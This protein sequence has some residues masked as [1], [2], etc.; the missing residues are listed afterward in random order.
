VADRVTAL[1]PPPSSTGYVVPPRYWAWLGTARA[2]AALVW[3]VVVISGAAL[4][5]R[6]FHWGDDASDLPPERMRADGNGAH[7]QIDFGG[8]W[9]M[10]RMMATGHGREL[11]HRQRQ[12]QILNEAYPVAN[13]SVIQREEGAL[14][15]SFQTRARPGEEWQHDSS[16]LMNWFMGTDPDEWKKVGGASV[17]PLA[18]PPT[19]N[20]LVA[21]ALE[22]AADDAVTPEIVAKVNEPAVGGPLYPP[23]HAL[24]YAPLGAI[25]HPQQA[26]HLFQVICALLIPVAGLGVKVLTRG[27][28][29]WSVATLCLFFYPGTRGG[30]DLGQNPSISLCI[31]IWGW[32]LASRGYNVAGGMVWGLFAFKPVW[33]MAFFLVPLLMRRWRFALAMV[34]AGAAFGLLTLPFVG[35]ESWFQWLK[36]G[37]EASELYKINT[38]WITLSRDLQGIPRRL[39][40]D[41]D[42]PQLERDT[43]LARHLAWGLWGAV[44]AATVLVY[45]L[46]A[47]RKR[48][49]GISAGFLFLGAY[50]TCFHFMFYDALLS[51]VALAALFADPRP[52]FRTK[53][54]AVDPAPTEPGVPAERAL[55]SGTEPPRPL[56]ARMRGYLSSFPLTVVVAL[57]V[58]ECWLSGLELEA[59]VGIGYFSTPA[60]AGA[61]SGKVPHLR[62]GTSIRY[63]IDTFLLLALWAWCGWQLVRRSDRGNDPPEKMT[64]A[65]AMPLQ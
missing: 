25:D 3:L 17:A 16:N 11:Y 18:Q 48:P 40:L 14:P 33:A 55:P 43:P 7:A 63:P 64:N 9:L 31:A 6:A 58:T 4:T 39:V 28:V 42:K 15:R 32:V 47:D 1:S 19:G 44:F 36:I 12:R 56:G 54:F 37:Q 49:T 53:S 65:P 57:F 51:A 46:R 20:P 21:V 8:Q 41:F 27:R 22:K 59:T 13:E 29:W 35:I 30:L 24:F 26:Y 10:G 23:V 60:H 61:T 34:L 62:A 52:F 50:L 5:Y 2:R 45:A 38:N